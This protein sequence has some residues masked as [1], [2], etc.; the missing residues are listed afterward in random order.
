[1]RRRR[2]SLD[3]GHPLAALCYLVI[4]NLIVAAAAVAVNMVRW[5]LF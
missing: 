5:W 4:G 2:V 1:M 3:Y